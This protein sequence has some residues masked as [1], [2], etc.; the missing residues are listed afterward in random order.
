MSHDSLVRERLDAVLDRSNIPPWVD[1]SDLRS[2]LFK[3]VD[4][5]LKAERGAA[6]LAVTLKNAFDRQADAERGIL[7]EP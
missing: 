1:Q 6:E 4:R 7:H 2:E 3:V 5:M